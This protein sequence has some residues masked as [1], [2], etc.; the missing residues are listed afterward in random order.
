MK[1]GRPTLGIRTYLLLQKRLDYR[2]Q[3]EEKTIY[4]LSSIW[5]LKV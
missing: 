5:L 2:L 4:V 3:T 1:S